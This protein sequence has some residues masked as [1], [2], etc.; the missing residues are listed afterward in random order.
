M[1]SINGDL[2]LGLTPMKDGYCIRVCVVTCLSVY[3]YKSFQ[4]QSNFNRKTVRQGLTLSIKKED[5]STHF[6]NLER[7]ECKKVQRTREDI[8]LRKCLQQTK[9]CLPLS[10]LY[11]SNDNVIEYDLLNFDT[12]NGNKKMNSVQFSRKTMLL[13]RS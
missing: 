4:F 12:V 6:P 7:K 13:F 8:S 5:M 3:R 1:E 11:L 9:N 10:N 2:N